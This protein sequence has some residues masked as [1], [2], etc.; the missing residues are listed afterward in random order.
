MITHQIVKYV[1]K[2]RKL[3]HG[4][5]AHR[6][7]IF[8]RAWEKFFTEIPLTYGDYVHIKGTKYNGKIVGVVEKAEDAEW[9]GLKCRFI[10]VY[11]PAIENCKLYHH[12][13]LEALQ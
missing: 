2:K 10:E 13:E 11:I 3:K 5:N 9:V 7:I 6:E 12:S 8:D 4:S 1:L